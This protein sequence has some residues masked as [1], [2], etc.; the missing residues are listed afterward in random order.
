MRGVA[1]ILAP[2]LTYLLTYCYR[3]HHECARLL[4]G[5]AEVARGQESSTAGHSDEEKRRTLQRFRRVPR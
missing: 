4:R 1:V 5:G 2:R 3:L